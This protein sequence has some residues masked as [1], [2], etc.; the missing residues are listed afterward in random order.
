MLDSINELTEEIKK[1]GEKIEEEENR[2]LWS[3]RAAV[4][5]EQLR[6][7]KETWNYMDMQEQRNLIC[8]VIDRIT[9]THNSV[10]I[11]YKY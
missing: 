1:L 2:G 11:D 8:S 9:V 3:Q 4:A 7:I 5:K 10:R 6:N